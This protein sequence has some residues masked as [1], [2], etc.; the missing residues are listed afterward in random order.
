M[1]KKSPA[2]LRIPFVCFLCFFPAISLMDLS[3]RDDALCFLPSARSLSE[4]Y[5]AAL[6]RDTVSL[7]CCNSYRLISLSLLPAVSS[8]ILKS[9]AM[10]L[11]CSM[12]ISSTWNVP[13][14]SLKL[15]ILSA[16]L[17]IFSI[18]V[19]AALLSSPV[20][21]RSRF[22]RNVATGILKFSG[23]CLVSEELS[24]LPK[25][26]F[27]FLLTV[28]MTVLLCACSFNCFC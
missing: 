6:I 27:A 8:L 23:T 12:I 28:L 2:I 20:K 14:A 19:T 4:L 7:N 11:S 9:V 17:P 24:S 15:R 25:R 1:P 21:P 18:H 16:S 3:A 22:C 10:S 13:L 5:I 26:L